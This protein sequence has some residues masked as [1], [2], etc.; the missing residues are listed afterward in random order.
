MSYG[1]VPRLPGKGGWNVKPIDKI[2]GVGGGGVGPVRSHMPKGATQT[3]K[4]D[5]GERRVKES[6]T[7]RGF[8]NHGSYF[9]ASEA[10]GAK[11]PMPGSMGEK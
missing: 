5:L 7:Q 3:P 10:F 11:A 9:D 4:G 1:R 2:V 6:D 8:K